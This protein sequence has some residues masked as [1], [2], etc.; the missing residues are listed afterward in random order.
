MGRT[1][2]TLSLLAL[3]LSAAHA[4]PWFT[5]DYGGGYWVF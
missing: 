2:A 5:Q 1:A 3:G 4:T